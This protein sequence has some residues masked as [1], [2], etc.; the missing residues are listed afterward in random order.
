MVLAPRV[1]E[2]RTERGLSQENLAH[3]AGLSWGAVQKL[4][5]GQVN[6]PHYSTLASIARVLDTTVVELVE[7]PARAD[8]LRRKALDLKAEWSRLGKVVHDKAAEGTLSDKEHLQMLRRMEEI[9]RRISE[10]RRR[11]KEIREQLEQAEAEGAFELAG[12]AG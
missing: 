7:G 5:A 12:A 10:I 2:L 3:R 1:K 6:D 4:E 11:A 9:E 8:E